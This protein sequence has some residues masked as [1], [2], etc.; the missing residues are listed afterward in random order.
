MLVWPRLEIE[1]L[2]TKVTRLTEQTTQHTTQIGL[3]TPLQE[4]VE[5]AENQIIKW[6]YRP[7]ELTDDED[8]HTIITAVEV[9][10]QLKNFRELTRVKIHEIRQETNSLDEK[11]GILER[12]RSESWE[13]VSHRL[14]ST[15]DGTATTLSD[16]MTELEQ[17]VQ[18]QT[19]SPATLSS[20]PQT[21][22]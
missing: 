7:P 10:K 4:R 21:N 19:T 14:N 16:R 22:P 17:M 18:S 12:A 15:R 20:Q 13:L 11:I 1:D 8:T 9:Q 3:L 5:L 2:K 6:R